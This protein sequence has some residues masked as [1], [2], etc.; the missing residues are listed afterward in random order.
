MKNSRAPRRVPVI[1]LAAFLAA[2]AL[3]GSGCGALPEEPGTA[4]D[5]DRDGATIKIGVFEPLT[6]KDKE[7][8]VLEIQGIELA[9]ALYPTVAGKTVELVYADNRS[10]IEGAQAAAQELVDQ[11]VS[12]V[13]GSYGSALSL[14]GSDVFR[15][16]NLPALAATPTNPL[17]TRGNPYYFRIAFVDAFQGAAAARLVAQELAVERVAVLKAKDDDAAA[18]L[19]QAFDS[20]LARRREATGAEEPPVL[21]LEY[22]RKGETDGTE[23][24]AALEQ[25]KA[26]G[27]EL[28][29]LP[30]PLAEALEL[31]NEARERGIGAVFLGTDQWYVK[32]SLTQ[33]GEA[34]EGLMFATLADPEAPL[35]DRTAE[36]LD[37]FHEAY[38]SDRIPDPAVAL[39][40][41]AYLLAIDALQRQAAAG[42]GNAEASLRGA[43]QSTNGFEGATGHFYFDENGDP[44]KTVLF[45]TVENGELIYKYALEPE[46]R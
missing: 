35:S 44:V 7:A 23:A 26:A 37:A 32:G 16:A 5:T 19:S 10:T 15:K 3:A 1:F 29:F 4:G 46:D 43:I 13:L 25:I 45:V 20:E 18:A 27:I 8:A 30:A 21:S 24:E 28:V 17:V 6:G 39:G 11:G 36:F 9:H 14:A 31:V 12:L 22:D 33:G 40:F 41:D 42:P 34:A 38:G 2:F